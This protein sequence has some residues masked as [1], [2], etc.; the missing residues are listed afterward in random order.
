MPNGGIYGCCGFNNPSISLANAYKTDAVTGLPL[1]DGSYNTGK[2]VSDP[3]P[4]V[5]GTYT[6]GNKYVGTLDPRIDWTIGRPG[7]PYFDMV[8]PTHYN[9]IRDPSTDG[10][11][12]PKKECLRKIAIR[13]ILFNRKKFWGPTQA[14]ANN[15]NLIRYETFF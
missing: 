7:L 9:W 11:M 2:N 6:Y 12:N 8:V 10:Y 14:D 1:L 15:T 3:T 5:A 4:I 13:Y